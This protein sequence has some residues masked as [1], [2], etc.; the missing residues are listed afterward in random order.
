[1]PMHRAQSAGTAPV[2]PA[3]TQLIDAARTA[4]IARLIDLSRRNNLLFYRPIPTSSIDIPEESP[5][6]LELLSGKTV[7]AETLLPDSDA[8]PGRV[9][10]IA[11]KAQENSEE[12]GLQTLY[13]AVGFASWQADDG[14]RDYQAPVFLLPLQM[15]RKGRELA[16]IEVQIA[17]EPQVNPVLLHVLADQSGVQVS[18]EELITAATQSE[19]EEASA[20]ENSG[21]TVLNRYQEALQAFAARVS[22]M[23]KFRV[24]LSAVISNFSFAKL[25]LVNDLRSAG[26]RLNSNDAVAAIAGDNEAR[27]HLGSAQVSIDPRELDSRPPDQEFCVVEADSSQQCAIAGIALGQHA[28]IHGP[29][30][31]GKSQTITNLI[32]TLVANGKKVLFVA[33][34]RAALEVVQQRLEKCGLDHLAMDLH[35]AELRPKTVMER[36]TRT[37]NLVRNSKPADTEATH[38][39]FQERRTKLNAH[40]ALMHTMSEFAGK[41]V[42][43]IQ[44]A[45]LRLPKEA[46]T[47]VRW[48]GPELA[49]IA[50]LNADR[51]R[52]L[53]GEAI[54][55]A[56][57]FMREDA[58]PWTGIVFRNGQQTQNA[59]D[60]AQRLQHE[61]LPHLNSQTLELVKATGFI[62]PKTLADV[63]EAV[64]LLEGVQDYMTRYS[65]EAFTEDVSGLLAELGKAKDGGLKGLWLSWTNGSIKVSRSA[66]PSYG[67]GTRSA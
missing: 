34:K 40:D 11:R 60:L 43:D 32:A 8:R 49:N 47:S 59:V 35:G 26:E 56:S 23:P 37:L 12:K 24:E 15:K 20:D 9:L 57:L 42:Y 65:N 14:G 16:A 45:L 51:I 17:G 52:D 39:Q 66:L 64:A 10:A 6:L 25:A 38:R 3:R 13:L 53:L 41:T 5:A 28:V 63:D 48:R 19:P 44:G 33:E 18:E 21:A 29:P 27:G 1:M 62:A 4:W 58:S 22:G 30:G 36:V 2:D 31:T 67:M 61:S 50:P 55:F 46:Q 7:T 54:P